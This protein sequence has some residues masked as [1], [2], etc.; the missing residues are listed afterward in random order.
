MDKMYQVRNI[1][2]S[3][4]LLVNKLFVRLGKK[5]S[6]SPHSYIYNVYSLYIITWTATIEDTYK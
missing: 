4:Y 2:Q 5:S 3:G 1:G 6:W